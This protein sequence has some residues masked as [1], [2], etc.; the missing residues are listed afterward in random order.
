[1]EG[2]RLERCGEEH[3][4]L[5][6][7]IAA[8]PDVQRFTRVPQ[9]CPP[10]FAA[11]WLQLYEEGRRDGTR[12]AFAVVGADGAPLGVAVAPRIDR[13]ARTAELGYVVA[14]EARGRGVAGE[15]LR[16]L[17]DWA[18]SK[19]ELAR[20]ELLISVDNEASRRVAVRCGYVREGVLRSL[21]LKQDVRDDTEIW[22][23]LA[24]DDVDR[25]D[26]DAVREAVRALAAALAGAEPDAA[27]AL[28]T[29]DVR[30]VGSRE[31]EQ[32]N[33]REALV[34]LLERR[35]SGGGG[36]AVAAW[37]HVD[38]ALHGDVALV[39]ASAAAADGCGGAPSLLS[40]VLVRRH[41]RW[42]WRVYHCSASARPRR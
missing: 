20:L 31:G 15:A 40:G 18:L 3:L 38:V 35:A 24:S 10:G 29:P 33:G 41:G 11:A 1:V 23:R 2:I 4:A 9:P 32:A 21:H 25:S 12:E 7:R 39:A 14:R 27:A 22:S 13:E 42:R 30:F 6:E 19:L 8:D 28:C 17:T 34:A 26:D 36:G 37:S 16:Q 5:L